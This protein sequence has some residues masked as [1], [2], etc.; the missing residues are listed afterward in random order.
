MYLTKYTFNLVSIAVYLNAVLKSFWTERI[1]EN[2][3]LIDEKHGVGH[4][5]FLVQLGEKF[6]SDRKIRRK[7]PSMENFN[8]FGIDCSE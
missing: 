3:G 2:G 4:D 6:L 5:V 1:G 8:D 7:E